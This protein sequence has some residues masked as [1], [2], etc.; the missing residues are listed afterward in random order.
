MWL[1]KFLP[2]WIFYGIF[3]A[4]LIGIAITYLLKYIP[5]PFIYMYKT[6]IQLASIAALAIGTFMTGAI[7]DNDA[8]M[9]RVKEMEE[10]V[11]IAEQQSKEANVVIEK[12]VEVERQKIVEKKVFLTEYIEKESAKDDVQCVI[13]QWFIEAHN[14]AAEK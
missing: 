11:A 3:F 14:K 12:K 4:G 9:A 1:I 5:I 8:W 10:K 13:P 2:D 6:P 7:Y